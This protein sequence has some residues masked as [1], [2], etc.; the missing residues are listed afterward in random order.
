MGAPKG[1]P[2]YAGGGRPKGS[3]DKAERIRSQ[4]FGALNNLGGQ[5]FIE[6]AARDEP[7]AFLRI[8]SNLL[9]KEIDADIT[10]SITVKWEQ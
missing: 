6:R 5:E 7:I 2:A 10:G 9:P 1:H 4:F 3:K 8:C